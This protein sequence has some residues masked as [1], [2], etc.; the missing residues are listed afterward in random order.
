MVLYLKQIAKPLQCPDCDTG[1]DFLIS[2]PTKRV[3]VSTTLERRFF[4]CPNCGRLIY[5]LVAMPTSSS[6]AA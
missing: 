1:L 2:Q 5:Q 4:L 3:F 6:A